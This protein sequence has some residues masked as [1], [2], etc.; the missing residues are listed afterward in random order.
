MLQMLNRGFALIVCLCRKVQNCFNGECFGEVIW[1]VV[2]LE[3]DFVV[4]FV[5]ADTKRCENVLNHSC[6]L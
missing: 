5:E 4:F 1:N 2:S 6:K 3:S